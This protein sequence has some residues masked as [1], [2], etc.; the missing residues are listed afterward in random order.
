MSPEHAIDA[1]KVSSLVVTAATAALHCCGHTSCGRLSRSTVGGMRSACSKMPGDVSRISTT[2][3]RASCAM[4]ATGISNSMPSNIAAVPGICKRSRV[5]FMQ[6]V[7][8]LVI[9]IVIDMS[10]IDGL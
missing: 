9:C 8:F 5:F 7:F 3:G 10:G 6:I 2:T 1:S 4:T